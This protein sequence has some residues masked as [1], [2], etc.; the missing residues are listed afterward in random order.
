MVYVQPRIMIAHEFLGIHQVIGVLTVKIRF[1]G[2][3]DDQQGK[4]ERPAQ[5][6]RVKG[7]IGI[8]QGANVKSLIDLQMKGAIAV[9]PSEQ[10]RDAYSILKGHDR[11]FIDN[12]RT[13]DLILKELFVGGPAQGGG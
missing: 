2:G 6:A 9:L 12:T 1:V 4:G 10:A 13:G 7:D 11:V 8:A 5:I 3:M